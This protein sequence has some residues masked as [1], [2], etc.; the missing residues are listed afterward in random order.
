MALGVETG[1]ERALRVLARRSLAQGLCCNTPG[2]PHPKDVRRAE[3]CAHAD[4]CAGE[5]KWLRELARA[6]GPASGRA[7]TTGASAEDLKRHGIEWEG[8]SA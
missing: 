7:T 5:L 4:E 2:C 6:N 3:R 8:S 1:I